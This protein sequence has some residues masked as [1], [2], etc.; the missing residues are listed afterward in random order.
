VNLVLNLISLEFGRFLLKRSTFLSVFAPLWADKLVILRYSIGAENVRIWYLLELI[1]E[2]NVL[3]RCGRKSIVTRLCVRLLYHV[4]LYQLCTTLNIVMVNEEASWH[5]RLIWYLCF[6]IKV[7]LPSLRTLHRL[8]ICRVSNNDTTRN[9]SNIERL[10]SRRG[11]H[12][13]SLVPELHSNFLAINLDYF[14]RKVLLNTLILFDAF[15]WI[16]CRILVS[17]SWRRLPLSRLGAWIYAA[18]ILLKNLNYWRLA[19]AFLANNKNLG[20][21]LHSL[22]HFDPIKLTFYLLIL[23]DSVVIRVSIQV[24]QLL[25]SM[26]VH[27]IHTI[28]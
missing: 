24:M 8:R 17:E 19:R 21:W 12:V 3:I 28:L 18:L 13:W 11:T 23:S 2:V 22:F 26:W 6:L 15:S 20:G 9:I 4:K 1:T 10:K 27:V 16:W 25:G 14:E 5:I 7:V